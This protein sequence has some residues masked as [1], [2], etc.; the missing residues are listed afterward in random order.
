MIILSAGLQKSGSGLIFNILNDIFF[1]LGKSNIR[2]LKKEL[3]CVIVDNYNCLLLDFQPFKID[4]FV[5]LHNKGL[6]FVVK[7]HAFPNNYLKEL[8]DNNGIFKI[9]YIYRDPRDVILSAIDHCKK[10][11]NLAFSKCTSVQT[12]VPILDIWLKSYYEWEKMSKNCV[13]FIKYEKLIC[14]FEESIAKILDFFNIPLDYVL[15]NTLKNKY[16]QDNPKNLKGLHYNV[17][18]TERFR[19]EMTKEEILFC[20]QY[21]KKHLTHMNYEI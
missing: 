3:E 18:K 1:S 13:F 4:K 15:I 10:N 16:L 7:T 20:N 6:T 12:T 19:Q 21:L 17:G 11:I 8:I 2:D 14:D 9:I 5:E